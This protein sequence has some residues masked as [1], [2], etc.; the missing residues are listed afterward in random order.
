[1]SLCLAEGAADR[2]IECRVR[3]R[4]V[5]LKLTLTPKFLERSFQAAVVRARP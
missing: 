3:L 2:T 4:S 5:E 1:M